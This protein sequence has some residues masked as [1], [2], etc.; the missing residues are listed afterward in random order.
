MGEEDEG[1]EGK[2]EG[3]DEAELVFVGH[4][5]RQPQESH[6]LTLV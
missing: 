1:G 4:E 3:E 5:E 6:D 2:E